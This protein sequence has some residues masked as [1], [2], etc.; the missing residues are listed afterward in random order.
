M[1]FYQHDIHPRRRRGRPARTHAQGARQRAQGSRQR[2]ATAGLMEIETAKPRKLLRSE[3]CDLSPP[4]ILTDKISQVLAD[5]MMSIC[6]RSLARDFDRCEFARL[7]AS[8]SVAG[9]GDCRFSVAACGRCRVGSTGD[10]TRID[11]LHE[12]RGLRALPQAQIDELSSRVRRYPK[13]GGRRSIQGRA[14]S[15]WAARR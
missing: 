8:D 3:T 9:T 12:R 15:S 2:S 1:G 6:S 10:R 11:A 13:I 14:C 7:R 4:L 5:L